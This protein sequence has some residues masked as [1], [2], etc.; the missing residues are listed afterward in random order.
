[1]QKLLKLGLELSQKNILNGTIQIETYLEFDRSWGLGSSSTLIAN[2]AK[3]LEIDPFLLLRSI[4][5]GSGYDVAVGLE[6]KSILYRTKDKNQSW[7]VVEWAPPFL[8]D[9]YFV[10]LGSKQKSEKEI[11]AYSDKAKTTDS[12]IAWFSEAAMNIV[13]SN[14]FQ[15]FKHI[16]DEHE[17][18]LSSILSSPTVR[19]KLGLQTYSGIVKSLG[20]WGG[21]FIMV[22]GEKD[23]VE[24]QF[25]KLG[26][27]TIIPYNQMVL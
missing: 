21:D 16:I 9:L 10:H 2:L 4:S 26:L 20:A 5:K 12:D 17:D 8:N 15:T 11:I 19:K 24:A 25:N 3:W 13:K 23:E 1:L 7:E 14:D 27:P 6:S 22:S 18:R